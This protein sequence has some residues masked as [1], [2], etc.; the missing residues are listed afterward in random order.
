MVKRI[1]YLRARLTRAGMPGLFGEAAM[2]ALAEHVLTTGV[3]TPDDL[4]L[5]DG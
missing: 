3:I 4:A 5:L 2:E 1:E